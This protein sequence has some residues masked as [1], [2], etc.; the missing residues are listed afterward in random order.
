MGIPMPGWVTIGINVLQ[1]LALT[2]VTSLLNLKVFALIK[3]I[4]VKKVDF[5]VLF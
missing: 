1:Y 4:F 3:L 5:S 2:E